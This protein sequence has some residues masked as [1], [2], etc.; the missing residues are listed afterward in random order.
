MAD[1]TTEVFDIPLGDGTIKTV[2][3]VSFDKDIT[4]F[5]TKTYGAKNAESA[6]AENVVAGLANETPSVF[7]YETLLD[8]TAPFF[9]FNSRTKDLAPEKRGMT[10]K[11]I[12]DNFTN[13]KDLGFFEGLGRE[14]TKQFPSAMAAYGGFKAGAIA[15]ASIPPINPPLIALKYGLPVVTGVIAG[16]EGY[17]LG[18]AVSDLAFG[19]E[20]AVTPSQSAAYESGKTVGGG[21]GWLPV[22]FMIPRKVSLGAAQYLDNLESMLA[23]GPI[24]NAQALND[25][26]LVKTLKTGKS[27]KSVRFAKSAE[28]LLGKIGT[29]FK[30]KPKRMFAAETLSVA[31]AGALAYQAE[32]AAPGEILPR[33]GAEIVGG[34]L[35]QVGFSSLLKYI[36]EAKQAIKDKG[37]YINFFKETAKSASRG[38]GETRQLSGARRILEILETQG[39][40][41]PALIKA[42]EDPEVLE[43][44]GDLDLNAAQ[45]TGNPTLMAI[46][47]SIAQS[48]EGLGK[49]AREKNKNANLAIRNVIAILAETGDK[50]L[51]KISS[52]MQQGRF[53]EYI[54]NKLATATDRLLAARASVKG[55]DPRN[56]RELSKSLFELTGN[57]LNL[58]RI[59][60]KNLYRNIGNIEI[61][62]FSNTAGSP[63]DTPRFISFLDDR[64]PTTPEALDAFNDIPGMKYIKSFV[65][66]KRTELGLEEVS[67]VSEAASN[68]INKFN[69]IIET[70][71]AKGVQGGRT[72]NLVLNVIDLERTKL[73]FGDLNTLDETQLTTLLE[74]IRSNPPEK[75]DSAFKGSQSRDAMRERTK[76]FNNEKIRHKDALTLVSAYKGKKVE[77]AST[78]VGE[79]AEEIIPLTVTEIRNMRTIA[80]NNGKKLMAS[81][82]TNGAGIMYGFAESL[83]DDLE[84]A[85]EGINKTFDAARSYSKS[86][87]D[88]FTRAFAGNVLAKS[89]TGATRKS[90]ELLHKDLMTTNADA[91]YIRIKQ[92]EEIGNFARD[93][94]LEGADETISTINGTMDSILRNVR[95]EVFTETVD[96]DVVLNQRKLQDWMSNN[97]EILDTFPTL[98]ADLQESVTANNLLRGWTTKGKN[99]QKN[100][101]SQITYRNLTGQANP[102]KAVSDAF[103]SKFP[104]K[105]LNSLVKPAKNDPEAL[106]GLKHSVLEWALTKGGKTSE[107]FSPREV[108]TTLYSK[109]PN[110]LGNTSVMKHMLDN[111]VI[112]TQESESFKRLITEMVKLEAAEVAGTLQTIERSG[113]ILDMY[114]RITGAGIG[115]RMS[116]VMG[117]GSND[118]IAGGAGSKALRQ[119]FNDIPA[120]M[121][122]DIMTEVMDNP[123][124]L[125]TLLK[126]AKT[127]PEKLKLSKR[128]GQIFTEAGFFVTGGRQTS[129]RITPNI[130]RE[131]QDDNAIDPNDPR[132]QGIT[133]EINNNQQSSVEPRLPTGTPTT[134]VASNQPFLS[135]LNIAPAEGAGSSS[136]SANTDRSQYASLFPND[137]ISGMI[138][139]TATMAQ[140]GAVPP[141]QTEIK[142]Q[143]HMLAYITPQ[144]GDILQLM[145]GS[146]RPGPMGIPSYSYGDPD[147]DSDTS[148]QPSSGGGSMGMDDDVAAQAAAAAA[149]SPDVSGLE[150]MQ[151]SISYSPVGPIGYDPFGYLQNK[152]NQHARN[153]LSRGVSPSFSRD[154]KGNVTSVTGP[155]GPTSGMPGIG[156][157]LSMIGTNMGFTTT[158]G[159]NQDKS[160][161]SGNDGNNDEEL[162]IRQ[163]N[164]NVQVADYVSSADVYNKNPNQYTLNMS[165]INSLRN[166]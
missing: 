9:D 116:R 26:V 34:V 164:P 91:S 114:L 57:Q 101:S 104:I 122:T 65:D 67:E 24:T 128:L 35:P 130:S 39:D 79:I 5:I 56:N 131:L 23:K 129:I 46:H 29:E 100:I 154:A 143:P 137:I 135:G 123:K 108:Y 98:K 76:R 87:N 81:G 66:R 43:M 96:G 89:K 28:Q 18:E 38:F 163:Y 133:Q 37:G 125:A 10:N 22:P 147:A 97:K 152:M 42:L 94:G 41:I 62:S 52:K 136:P 49:Q 77:E 93:Q 140:G 11:Q 74:R 20:K 112:N 92:I 106:A 109:I 54:T 110:A 33:I 119:I 166:R 30:D 111:K 58:A 17:N 53:N 71:T 120:S 141:R 88:V 142:G 25:K 40:D 148:T 90:P 149:Q 113:P 132:L 145:G 16:V 83:L 69:K 118:L 107:T 48:T 161:D 7:T 156:S 84:G 36:P 55:T 86:L 162:L 47:N 14:V 126:K 21:L 115:T 124:L 102:T 72:D 103:N 165:G 160:K 150:T 80:L 61:T 45:K 151:G 153:S 139:P 85:P 144:E 1:E 75:L 2:P 15:T 8:G 4:D 78:A 146:G 27:P 82:D 31:G 127:E 105:S 63:T 70:T 117:L 51:I 12:L 6:M 64:A 138:Q 159:Y 3:V 44:V 134:Q 121:K 32:K 59:E 95:S 158:T 155:G 60:E 50:D 99:I 68:Q 13:L 19:E 157:L 73:D